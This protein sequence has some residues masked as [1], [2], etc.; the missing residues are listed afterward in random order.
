MVTCDTSVIDAGSQL[1]GKSSRLFPGYLLLAI[2]VLAIGGCTPQQGALYEW[3]QYEG[4]L[5]ANWM[6]PDSVPPA[7]ASD[8]LAADILRAESSGR[9]VGP[10]VHAHLGWL[11][12]LQGLESEARA[13]LLAER[14]LFPESAVMVDDMLSRMDQ[15]EQSQEPT[16]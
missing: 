8:R 5:Y 15:P 12:W 9:E 7:D 10:G 1:L 4:L 14:S 16:L 11:Y 6:Q 3:G 13:E 2:L